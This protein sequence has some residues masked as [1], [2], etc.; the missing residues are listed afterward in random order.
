M[1]SKAIAP[2][3]AA[4]NAPS[5]ASAPSAAAPPPHVQLIQMTMAI[6]SARALYAAAELKLADLLANGPRDAYDLARAT[7]THPR[8]L[9]R[10]LRALA[11]AGVLTEVAPQRFALTAL[12]AALKSDAPG[13][14]RATVLTFAGAWQWKA[15]ENF[16]FSLQTGEPALGKA[17]G[18]GLFDYLAAHPEDGARFGEAMIGMYRAVGPAIVEAYDF[19]PLRTVV[20][21]GGGTGT[22][23]TTILRAT[24]HLRG[25]LFELPHTIPEARRTVGSM[26][27]AA[28]CDV[29]EGDFFKAVPAGHDAYIL[30]HVLHDWNDQQAL[31]ILQNCRRAIAKDG[32]LLIVEAVLPPGDTP[33]HGKLIDLLMMTVTG[34][35][36]RTAD[37]YAALL[38]AA[39]FKLARIVPT[40][41]PHSVVEA[42]AAR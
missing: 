11:S 41:T 7:G 14:A 18:V 40:S 37:E 36:E 19:S 28:R 38:G 13:A 20:D 25:I 16:L 17:F 3:T 6:W 29:V 27:L 33:H 15:W 26:G 9:H 4:A 30:S 8:S 22:L 2:E 34:G 39:D 42:F 5:A 35:M 31:S 24:A 12:G 32:R 1:T 23:L 21:L 10:L